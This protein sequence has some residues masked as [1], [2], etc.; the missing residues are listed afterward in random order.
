MIFLD[1]LERSE[2]RATHKKEER[3][4]SP[5]RSHSL[6]SRAPQHSPSKSN[7]ARIA[8]LKDLQGKPDPADGDDDQ[9]K[10]YVGGNAQGGGGS[11]RHSDLKRK[12]RMAG[13]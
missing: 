4:D 6:R 7:M 5:D 11:G 12:R 9:N 1:G 3:S 2:R 8:G 13:A 10:Y